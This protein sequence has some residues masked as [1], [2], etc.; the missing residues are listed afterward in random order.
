MSSS[1]IMSGT[2]KLDTMTGMEPVNASGA[3]PTTV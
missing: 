2:K 3:T 1:V